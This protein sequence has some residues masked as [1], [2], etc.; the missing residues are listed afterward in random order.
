M[1]LQCSQIFI[2]FFGVLHAKATFE[3]A[4]YFKVAFVYAKD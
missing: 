3:V 2:T 1:F 4:N